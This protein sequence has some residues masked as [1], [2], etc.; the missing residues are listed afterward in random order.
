MGI[1]QL[2]KLKTTSLDK[3]GNAMKPTSA[4]KRFTF[5]I[6]IVIQLING[7]LAFV[8]KLAARKGLWDTQG[9]QDYSMIWK[10]VAA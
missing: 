5:M 3:N 10:T 8:L 9:E 1:Y 7:V 4:D 2:M 6:T